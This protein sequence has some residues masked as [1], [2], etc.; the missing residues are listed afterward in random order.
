METSPKFSHRMNYHL[1]KTNKQN[2]NK[3]KQT[4]FAIS[5]TTDPGIES[6]CLMS[7]ALAG[8]FFTTSAIRKAQL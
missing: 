6:S 8:R 5:H 2:N 4:E 1:K 7:P 3:K